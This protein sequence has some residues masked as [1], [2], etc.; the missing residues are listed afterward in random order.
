M[1]CSYG[2]NAPDAAGAIHTDFKKGFI[3]AE[4]IS[5]K[6]LINAGGDVNAKI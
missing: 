1:D 2:A 5:Y 6:D 3:A 4:V